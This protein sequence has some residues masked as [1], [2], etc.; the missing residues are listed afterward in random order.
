MGCGYLD[1]K[2]QTNKICCYV[3]IISL[4]AFKIESSRS[5]V[6]LGLK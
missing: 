5:K 3:F 4:N 6:V 2:D 1:V